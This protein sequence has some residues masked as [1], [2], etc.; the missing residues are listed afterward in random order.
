MLEAGGLGDDLDFVVERYEGSDLHNGAD[1]IVI[2]ILRSAWWSSEG[3]KFTREPHDDAH[4][5]EVDN[6]G[7]GHPRDGDRAAN[8]QTVTHD[9]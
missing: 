7:S 6:N 1:L 9:G 8:I 2:L 5:S 3:K 4:L